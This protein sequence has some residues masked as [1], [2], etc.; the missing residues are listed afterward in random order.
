MADKLQ[1][2]ILAGSTS[3]S[4]YIAVRKKVDNSEVTGLVFNTAGNIASYCRTLG[5]RVAITLA[6][7]TVTGAYAS[8]GFVEVDATNMPG[9]YRFDVPDAAVAAG[10]DLVTVSFVST[11]NYTTH[12]QYALT[13]NVVQTGDSFARIG[14]AGVSLTNIGT[15]ATV[16]NLTNLP[17]IPANWLT[18]TGINAG[19]ITASKFATDAV[20]GTAFAANAATKVADALLDRVDGI[21]TGFTFR[22]VMRLLSSAQAG[23]VS[24]AAT[25]TVV[26]RNITDVKARITATVDA[27]GNRSAITTDVT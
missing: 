2:G 1:G 15:I 7:Q 26:I 9:I 13:T 4:L 11:S 27:S 12:L 20:D 22:Q 3:V 19:A 10:V 24:G 17:A 21:E 8:G 16:T 5:A 6:T 14:A 25:T 18:A 23:K